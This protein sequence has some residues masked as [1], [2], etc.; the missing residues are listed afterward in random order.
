MTYKDQKINC[1]KLP[2]TKTAR[3]DKQEL[4]L[5][6]SYMSTIQSYLK[7]QWPTFYTN[8]SLQDYFIA[9]SQSKDSISAGRLIKNLG[10][11]S[12]SIFEVDKQLSVS[13]KEG[14]SI[15]I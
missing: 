14:E 11:E 6:K 12:V 5:Y 7:N 3:K 2:S 10:G 1:K 8:T 13:K 15:L 9:L 4:K